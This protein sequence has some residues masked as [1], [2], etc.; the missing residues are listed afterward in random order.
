MAAPTVRLFDA[1]L[2]TMVAILCGLVCVRLRLIRPEEGD[3]KGR[4]EQ[5][6]CWIY[7][8]DPKGKLWKCH[9]KRWGKHGKLMESVMKIH[10]KMLIFFMED[11]VVSTGTS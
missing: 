8:S 2:A 7:D 3:L 6:R 4:W 10:M 9:V 5:G 1:L 11:A